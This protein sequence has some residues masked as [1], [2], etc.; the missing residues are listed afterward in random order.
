MFK[1]FANRFRRLSQLKKNVASGAVLSGF[2]TLA[3]FVAYPLY[4]KYLGAEQYGLWATVS[5]VLVFCRLGQFGIDTAITKYVAAE[6]GRKNL[7]AITEYISTAFYILMIPSLIIVGILGFF[8]SYI[9][10]LLIAD[11]AGFGSVGRLIFLVGILSMLSLFVNIMRGVM[12]GIGRMDV[13][14]YVSAVGRISQV[15]LALILLLIGCGIWSLYFGFLLSY[16]LPLTVWVLILKYTYRLHLFKPLAFRRHK[17]GELLRYGGGLTTASVGNMLVMPFN[18]LIIARYVGLSEVAYYQIATRVITSLRGVFVQGLQALL[19]KISEIKGKAA[20]A[21]ESA[22]KIA[23]IRRK[24]ILFVL[25]C[26]SP[27]FALLFVFAYP[28]LR[29]WLGGGFDAQIAVAARILL[30]GWLANILAAPDY[31]MFLGIGR[32][33]YIITGTWLRSAANVIPILLLI[34]LGR[35]FS[36][37][38]VVA[39]TSASLIVDAVYLK[40]KYFNYSRSGKTGRRT[41]L[42]EYARLM[43][44]KRGEKCYTE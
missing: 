29:L 9:A 31:F 22:G 44:L 27:P 21:A 23:A 20:G 4:L 3:G 42:S 5:V 11:G 10:G 17:L 6:Y 30:I 7:R 15:G 28:L 1:S 12:T 33:R 41:D 19:P 25:L 16:V 2:D 37:S 38:A 8:N 34:I 24:G 35:N 39:V 32:V 40:W 14:N 18:K 13:A 36:L 43:S 26:A